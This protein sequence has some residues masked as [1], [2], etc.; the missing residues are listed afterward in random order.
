MT[1][2]VGR[3]CTSSSSPSVQR[4]LGRARRTRSRTRMDRSG[5]ADVSRRHRFRS[6]RCGAVRLHQRTDGRVDRR[7]RPDRPAAGHHTGRRPV[8]ATSPA[9]TAP[10][11]TSSSGHGY[12]T[13]YFPLPRECRFRAPEPADERR[14]AFPPAPARRRVLASVGSRRRGR[15]AFRDAPPSSRRGTGPPGE[16]RSLRLT[17]RD[18]FG[19]EFFDFVGEWKRRPVLPATG[20]ATRR[21]VAISDPAS[22]RR[23]ARLPPPRSTRRRR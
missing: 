5:R 10:C 11:T 23:R 2:Q 8:S 12:E 21:C 6:H 17:G 4:R 15:T 22:S 3:H 14:S 9:S 16:A 19:Q 20:G 13:V 7:G 1:C 18:A